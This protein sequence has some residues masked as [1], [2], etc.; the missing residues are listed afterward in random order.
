MDSVTL[1]AVGVSVTLAE[2]ST[3]VA[4]HA[5]LAVALIDFFKGVACP[6]DDA[7]STGSAAAFFASAAFFAPAAL[8]AA[9][10]R[11]GEVFFKTF[12]LALRGTTVSSPTFQRTV[13]E[14]RQS[15]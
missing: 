8:V 7:T 14:T 11:A 10:P 4:G 1:F 13:K 9:A 12:C 6:R 3:P 5:A 15:R 2:A